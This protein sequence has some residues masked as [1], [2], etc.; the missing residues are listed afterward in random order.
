MEKRGLDPEPSSAAAAGRPRAHARSPERSAGE[1]LL[2]RRGKSVL[3]D[4]YGL[5]GIDVYC[6]RSC[7]TFDESKKGSHM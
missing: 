7:Y 1:A 6:D 4:H 2:V 5:E 3:K